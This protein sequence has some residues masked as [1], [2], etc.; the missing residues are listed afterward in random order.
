MEEVAEIE[1]II[2]IVIA[3]LGTKEPFVQILYGARLAWGQ[4]L[5]KYRC[6]VKYPSLAQLRR[7]RSIRHILYPTHTEE[8]SAGKY[9]VSISF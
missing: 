5:R 9:S 2:D 8:P 7:T 6:G 4:A 3:H 1:V